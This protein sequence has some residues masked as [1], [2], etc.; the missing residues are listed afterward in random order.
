MEKLE[1]ILRA[2]DATRF[3]LHHPF[4]SLHSADIAGIGGWTDDCRLEMACEH[5]RRENKVRPKLF[6]RGRS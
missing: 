5:V 2:A 3:M 1:A 4:N 6:A